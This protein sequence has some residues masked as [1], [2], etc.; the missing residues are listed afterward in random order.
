MLS[1][2]DDVLL[3]LLFHKMAEGF[4]DYIR[5]FTIL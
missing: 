2:V 1:F 5:I 4:V 3:C